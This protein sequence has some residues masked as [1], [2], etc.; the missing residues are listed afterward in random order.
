MAP[1]DLAT[2]ARPIL[3]HPVLLGSAPI[4]PGRPLWGT[5]ASFLA[6]VALPLGLAAFYL[7]E[8]AADRYA[9]RTAFSIRSNDTTAPLEIFG[10]ITQLGTSSSVMDGE[11]LYDFIQSQS[12]LDAARDTLDLETIYNRA[13]SDWFFRLGDAQPVEELLDH[14]QRM[15]DVSI[16][17]ATGILTVETRAFSAQDARA[18]ASSVLTASASLVN[19][20][21]EA[22]RDDAVGYAALELG[23]AEAR[24]RRIRTK[25][26]AFRDLEQEVDPT[27]NARAALGLVA[28]LEED[29]ARAQIQLDQLSGVLGP[30]A[31]RIQTLRRRLATLDGRIAEERTRLGSGS[32]KTGD[33]Q[34][35]DVVGDYEELLVDREFAE[36]AYTLSLATYEQAQAEARRQNR[37]LAVHIPPTLSE[38]AE[39]PDRWVWL[40]TIGGLATAL[41]AITLLILA[42]IRERR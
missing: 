34:L 4:R 24:L 6:F 39:Y 8:H 41:W 37:Y 23:E 16:N 7:W 1:T 35:A 31:P 19:E 9:S 28:A 14:W 18:L 25:L 42:N 2:N 26:R 5:L 38:E 12:M 13:P 3:E 22:A 15:T 30:Q 21:S 10:A 20:L 29:R 33:R 32:A 36:Q 17:P 11:I 40:G 27:Q